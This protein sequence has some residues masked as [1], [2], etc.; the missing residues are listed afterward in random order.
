[1]ILSEKAKQIKPSSTL[2][3]TAKANQMKVDGIDVVGFG[4]GEP[5]FDTPDHIKAA[6]I[7]AIN[8]GFTKYTPVAGTVELKQA[9][10]KKFEQDNQLTYK[11][12]QIVVSNGAKHSL[13]NAF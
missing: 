7:A 2:A 1:M 6:A 12:N 5:D 9:I 13:T 8:A 4:A 10:C 3:I 11:P